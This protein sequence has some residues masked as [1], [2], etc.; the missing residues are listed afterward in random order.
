MPTPQPNI[1]P[2][3]GDELA[4]SVLMPAEGMRPFTGDEEA[5]KE[6][7]RWT[8]YCQVNGDERP[9]PINL[10]DDCSVSPVQHPLNGR[11]FM[12]LRQFIQEVDLPDGKKAR[13]Y[14]ILGSWEL[15]DKA[16]IIQRFGDIWRANQFRVARKVEGFGDPDDELDSPE[17]PL[18]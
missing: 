17:D 10:D 3:S 2:E 13:E 5:R 11:F 8:K 4:L 12:I 18:A 16:A 15:P 6:V 14:D 7:G 9:W 1:G